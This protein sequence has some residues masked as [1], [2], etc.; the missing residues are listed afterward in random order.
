MTDYVAQ[1]VVGAGAEMESQEDRFPAHQNPEHAWAH[2]VRTRL[3]HP[4]RLC[5]F[6]SDS[7]FDQ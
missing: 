5:D 7:Y 2:L 1:V 3:L 6:D 4:V